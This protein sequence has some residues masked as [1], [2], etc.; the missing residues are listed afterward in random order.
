MRY[1][2]TLEYDGTSY[3]GWQIQS[4]RMTVQ[5]ALEEAIEKLCGERC[6]TITA[7]RTDAGVHA[8]GQV[9]HAD[10]PREYEPYKVMQG[11]NFH[12]LEAGHTGIAIVNAEA[13]PDTFNARFSATRRYYRYRMIAR[14]S[15]LAIDYNR[16]WLVV[17]DM[18]IA[19]MQ[20]AA[21]HLLGHHDFTSFRDSECQAKSPMRT[22]ESLTITQEGANIF[23][24]T[25]SR[26]F[27]HHQVRIMVGTLAQI[28]KG[29]WKPSDMVDI[30]SA[31]NRASAGPTAVPEGL[32]LVKVDY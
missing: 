18:D 17:E 13:V 9:A 12:L 2:L 6:A 15:R 16:A 29:R 30:L 14:R 31:K 21:N 7:G 8:L 3:A 20:E 27:L 28:G 22:L 10:L 26:S 23:V 1:K 25:H 11:L 4:D 5:Q 24:D 32:Y 19:A